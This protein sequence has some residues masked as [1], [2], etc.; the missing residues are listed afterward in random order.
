LRLYGGFCDNADV[1]TIHPNKLHHLWLRDMPSVGLANVFS[2]LPPLSS[3]RV[4]N[5]EKFDKDTFITVMGKLESQDIG[6]EVLQLDLLSFDL[7]EQKDTLLKVLR[8]HKNSLHSLA[9]SRNKITNNFMDTLC[10]Q[11]A[12][13]NHITN[14]TLRYLKETKDVKWVG[15]LQSINLLTN[16]HGQH[17]TVTLTGYQTFGQQAEIQKYLEEHIPKIDLNIV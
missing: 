11:L 4:D 1:D 17:I 7:E 16:K 12:D 9:F 15:I 8:K 3:F 13:D 10:G 2:N 6:L 14:I 5:V